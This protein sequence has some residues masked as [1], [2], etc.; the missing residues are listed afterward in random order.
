MFSVVKNISWTLFILSN[1]CA[2]EQQDNTNDYQS[3]Q[4]QTEVQSSKVLPLVA[5]CLKAIAGY[6]ESDQAFD[7]FLPTLTQTVLPE[8]LKPK[9]QDALIDHFKA[10]W[11]Y[12]HD[13]KS[14]LY[15]SC[16]ESLSSG[17]NCAAL[18]P[19]GFCVVG[20]AHSNTAAII[21]KNNSTI[22]LE[23]HKDEII[24]VAFSD[25]QPHECRIATA[26]KDKTVRIWNCF[27]SCLSV[28]N[29]HEDAV[30][31]VLLTSNGKYAI[32]GSKD[33]TVKIWQTDTGNCLITLYGHEK[34]V[35]AVA[36]SMDGSTLASASEDCTIRL[37]DVAMGNTIATLAGHTN[38]VTCIA[39]NRFGNMVI[40]GSLDKSV[41]CWDINN[42]QSEILLNA[43]QCHFDF[44]W[45][46]GIAISCDDSFF[47]T[48][49]DNG[50]V[51]LWDM[52]TK[53]P[54]HN[55]IFPSS[56]LNGLTLDT[57]NN[58]FL[59]TSPQKPGLLVGLPGPDIVDKIYKKRDLADL[60]QLL[61]LS[62]HKH[63]RSLLDKQKDQPFTAL[64]ETFLCQKHDSLDV[65]L[66]KAYTLYPKIKSQ[67]LTTRK[68]FL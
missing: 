68:Y 41:R 58:F 5:Y 60:G 59:V 27:G 65:F 44:N 17:M 2:M 7:L 63:S 48:A 33:K 32:T 6:Q 57:N 61:Y 54:V 51:S 50:Y 3:D 43:E 23:A 36:L 28:L 13:Q 49:A 26:S 16:Q 62:R 64:Q 12:Q 53:K 52:S 9:V 47:L 8:E 1:I 42:N 38:T 67:I 10:K 29:G 45:I 66:K 21:S 56:I 30:T 35:T 15:D 40:S 55:Y 11:G 20:L 31:S 14:P 4:V 19:Y 39:L 22:V 24:A 25:G 37:W 34:A 18:N 46:T